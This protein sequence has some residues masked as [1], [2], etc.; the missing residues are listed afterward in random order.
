VKKVEKHTVVRNFP[1]NMFLK[2]K[3]LDKY[4]RKL[5][6]WHAGEKYIYLQ[7][8][9]GPDR[10]PFNCISAALEATRLKT[11]VIGNFDKS[12]LLILKSKFGSMMDSRIFFTGMVNQLDIPSYLRSALFSII[13]YNDDTPNRRFCESN[14][15]YQ[16][17]SMGIP[18]IT[19][20]N[21]PMAEIINKYES[22]I[23][24]KSD[25]RDLEELKCSI[26]SLID[27]YDYYKHN[28]EQH[29][30]LFLW[31]ENMIKHSSF[32]PPIFIKYHPMLMANRITDA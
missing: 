1:D 9:A 16:A 21:P 18:V 6:N 28:A 17:L 5:S 3:G 27:N 10:Y 14:R 7:S 12:A 8:L 13:L 29:K 11:V 15:F 23:S 25:G 19:G 30:Q 24:M 2:S 26:K 32:A 20:R 4:F 22:G 31:D